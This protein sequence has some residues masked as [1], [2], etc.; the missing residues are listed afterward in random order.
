MKKVVGVSFLRRSCRKT[1]L[2]EGFSLLE[3]LVVIAIISIIMGMIT[4]ATTS[5]RKSAYRARAQAEIREISNALKA[6][7]ITYGYWPP[8]IEGVWTSEDQPIVLSS[9]L[10]ESLRGKGN[11]NS[12]VP[13]ENTREIVFL[14]LADDQFKADHYVDPWGSPY[15]I[16]LSKRTDADLPEQDFFFYT[17]VTFPMRDRYLEP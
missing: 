12:R 17:A 1:G 4:Y 10:L 6:Y 16:Y 7:W 11:P 14:E 15:R 13:G 8:E 2:R 3:L 5:A 9:R